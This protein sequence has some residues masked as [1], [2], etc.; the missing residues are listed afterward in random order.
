MTDNTSTLKEKIEKML[1]ET[2][3]EEI[4]PEEVS[5]SFPNILIEFAVTLVCKFD[6]RR[7]GNQ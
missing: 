6:P 7:R 4:T 5:S 3:I 1:H 2:G